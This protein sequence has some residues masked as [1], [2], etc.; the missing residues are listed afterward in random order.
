MIER[1]FQ[2]AKGVGPKKEKDIWKEGVLTWSDFIDA[3]HVCGMGDARKKKCDVTFRQ[4]YDMLDDGD[5]V[6][7]GE[8]LNCSEHWR[9]YD[10]F[11]N[12]AAYLDIETDGLDRDSLVTVVTVHRKNET[13]TLTCGIDLDG[14]ALSDALDGAKILVTFNGRCFDVPVLKNSFPGVDFDIPHYDLRF[15]C[16][17]IGLSGGLKKIE[18]DLG[19]RRS[20]DICGVDGE[21]AVRL[22]H[23]WERKKDRDALDILTE[24]NRADTVNL[25][26]IADIVYGRMVREYVGF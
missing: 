2:I 10:R 9:L 12:D 19:I 16:R 7:L 20:D 5:S 22:W 15:A 1:T 26:N 8:M 13:T 17:K 14:G 25:E 6:S 11:R 4:A 21:E 3:E 23:L 18:R 24:Y